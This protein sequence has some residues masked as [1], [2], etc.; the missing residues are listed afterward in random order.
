MMKIA[1]ITF[2]HQLNLKIEHG[3]V[4]VLQNIPG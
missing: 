1:I 3:E 4:Y 2:K